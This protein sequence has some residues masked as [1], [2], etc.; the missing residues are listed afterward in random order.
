MKRK[1]MKVKKPKARNWT[2]VHVMKK[3]VRKHRNK[4][5]EAKQ[6]VIND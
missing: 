3:P 6:E 5:R 2:V 1:K 4:K